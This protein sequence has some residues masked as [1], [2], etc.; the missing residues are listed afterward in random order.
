LFGG[1]CRVGVLE[2]GGDGVPDSIPIGPHAQASNAS[3]TRSAQSFALASPF[4]LWRTLH[5]NFIDSFAELPGAGSGQ[6][7]RWSLGQVVL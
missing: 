2:M 6:P 1:I 3:D 7:G 5:K 4:S